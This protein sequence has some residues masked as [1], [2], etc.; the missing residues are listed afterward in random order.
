M[1][2]RKLHVFVSMLILAAMIG[3]AAFPA[4]AETEDSKSSQV[5]DASEMAAPQEVGSEDMAPVYADAVAEGRYEVEVDSSSSM[6]RIVKAVLTVKDGKMSAVLTLSGKGYGKLF[7]GTGQ[8]AVN[9]GEDRYIPYV[10]DAAG[11]YT[12]E[13]SVEALDKEIPCAAWSIKKEKWYDRNLVFKAESLPEG[14]IDE[15]AAESGSQASG[16][17]GQNAGSSDKSSGDAVKTDAPDGMY[18]LEVTLEGG[19]GKASVT[20]PAEVTVKDG[21]VWAKIEW[22]S[23]NYDYMIVGG[24]RYEPVNESGNSVFEIPVLC[25]DEKFDVIG[26]TTA[27]STPHEVEYTL[28]FDSSGFEQDQKQSAGISA[29]AVILVAVILLIIAAGGI[30]AVRKNR[31][32]KQ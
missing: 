6:F 2:N 14:A 8:E 23:P 22:S 13:I 17:N 19:S 24:E 25:L 11:A 29:P 28:F 7:L 3:M 32:K 21:A 18:R 30:L 20:S 5:A 1:K 16:D 31:A 10:E 15:N 26:D 27:M 12:Y 4:F 9:A